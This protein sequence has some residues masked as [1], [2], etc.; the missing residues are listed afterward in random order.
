MN[1]R[2][3]LRLLPHGDNLRVDANGRIRERQPA[4]QAQ[5]TH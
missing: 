1:T 2:T 4:D 5:G 3:L